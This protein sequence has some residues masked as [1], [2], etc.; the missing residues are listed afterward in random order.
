[1]FTKRGREA[2]EAPRQLIYGRHSRE[3]ASRRA[4][5]GGQK[6][7]ERAIKRPLAHLS[8]YK[9]EAAAA[10]ATIESRAHSLSLF[11]GR[12]ERKYQSDSVQATF[13]SLSG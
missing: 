12:A 1:M 8:A 7:E 4:S 3:R 6:R 9:C 10:A 2:A 13:K 5:A 11:S